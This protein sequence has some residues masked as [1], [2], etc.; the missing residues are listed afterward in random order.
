M[1][2]SF[3]GPLHTLPSKCLK[4]PTSALLKIQ[5]K[6]LA[7]CSLYQ[8]KDFELHHFMV[9][10]AKAALELP[11]PHQASF[12]VLTRS[13][14]TPLLVGSYISW[15]RKFSSVNSRNLME[16]SS[17]LLC[18]LSNRFQGSW[19][20]PCG[21]DLVNVR[22]LQFVRRGPHQLNSRG[23]CQGIIIYIFKK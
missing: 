21:S 8:S 4:R 10:T 2:L 11:I 13:S 5:C 3:L 16:F 17:A 12:L 22:L 9:T 7:M 19:N 14:I 6:K 15:R 23:T 20:H 1:R 18:C